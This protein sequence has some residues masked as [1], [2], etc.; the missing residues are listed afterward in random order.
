[1]DFSG[2]AMQRSSRMDLYLSEHADHFLKRGRFM[3]VLSSFFQSSDARL[4]RCARGPFVSSTDIFLPPR[5]WEAKVYSASPFQKVG[6]WPPTP[7]TALAF[8]T[9]T[10][11]SPTVDYS[12]RHFDSYHYREC[13]NKYNIGLFSQFVILSNNI[14]L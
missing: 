13:L 10:R 6:S 12:D 8:R 11:P 9:P 14:F 5:K 4:A 1:V 7:A 3:N 2:K